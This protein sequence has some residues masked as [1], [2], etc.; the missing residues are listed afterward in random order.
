MLELMKSSRG[1]RPFSISL[2]SK[3]SVYGLKGCCGCRISNT[4]TG[5]LQKICFKRLLIP[6]ALKRW[7]TLF[8]RDLQY[9]Q[10]NKA[11]D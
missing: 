10:K 9:L 1:L 3:N 2:A 6:K 4:I 7:N 8:K 5:G 11:W